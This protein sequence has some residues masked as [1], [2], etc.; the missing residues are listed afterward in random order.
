MGFRI[1]SYA[2]S[3][4]VSFDR[5]VITRAL[6]AADPRTA[7]LATGWDAWI[8]DWKT[9][10]FQELDHRVAVLSA[11][12]LAT[13][14]DDDLDEIADETW[15]ETEGDAAERQ[16]YFSGKKRAQFTAPRLG[17]QYRQM[18]AWI[19][20]MTGSKE[21]RIVDIGN[22]LA[23]KHQAAGDAITDA[24]T[25]ETAARDFRL[26]GPRKQIIDRY[27]ALGKNTE[28]E[29]KEMP[30]AQPDLHLPKDFFERFL[31]SPRSVTPPTVEDLT[32]KRDAAKEDLDAIQA[33]LD[34][35]IKAEKDDADQ[36]AREQRTADQKLLAEAQAEAD[37]KNKAVADLRAKLGLPPVDP[38]TPDG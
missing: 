20:H 37:A 1:I 2:A 31:R 24:D 7:H 36:A 12:A 17:A 33:E 4:L 11:Q 13:I 26:T 27:N 18:G 3:L 22:R 28:G 8:I 19:T 14:M 16:F 34:A 25:K 15:S 23:K 10:F 6:L 29:L 30:F 5:A 21:P 38:N 35:A 32:K 9:T